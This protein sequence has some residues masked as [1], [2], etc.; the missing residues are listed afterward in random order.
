[1]RSLTG[2]LHREKSAEVSGAGT[3]RAARTNERHLMTT[4]PPAQKPE[5][6]DTLAAGGRRTAHGGGRR[7]QHR[8]AFLQAHKGHDIHMATRGP[9]CID[10]FDGA[11]DI[12]RAAVE[13]A[14]AG[15]PPRGMT[16]AETGIAVHILTARGLSGREI[17]LRVRRT[18]RTVCRHR[19]H[20][21]GRRAA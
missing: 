21:P 9:F 1:M 11:P 13:R 4:M 7:E 17:A 18:P 3:A 6:P 14:V 20:I 12:D 5:S 2:G 8:A 15:D 10:C 19:A 16:P